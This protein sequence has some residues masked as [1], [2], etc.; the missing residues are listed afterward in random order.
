M[1]VQI[2]IIS[3]VT[4]Q[5]AVFSPP[6]AGE[7]LPCLGWKRQTEQ[8]RI[9]TF[10]TRG[11]GTMKLII[12]EKPEL[13]RAIAAA[14]PGSARTEQSVIYKGEY[15]VVWAYGHL[16]TLKEP[17]D[18]DAQYKRWA[19]NTLPIFFPDWG[20]KPNDQSGGPGASKSQRLRQIGELL[21]QCDSVIHAGDPDE[22]G[23]Y[24]ID[25]RFVP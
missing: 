18:Y 5:M 3:P 9:V 11:E 15:A 20:Q 6:S 2:N 21:K 7:N 1:S 19:L 12:A 22:E 14:L 4:V 17:E 24:L 13:G 25:A 23:Q 10:E 16:L 8:T